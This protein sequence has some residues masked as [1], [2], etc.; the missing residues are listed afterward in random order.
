MGATVVGAFTALFVT[1][2]L[3][4][5]PH[6][7]N[8]CIVPDFEV[9]AAEIV[10]E[11]G[12]ATLRSTLGS[13]RVIRQTVI[14][15]L[16]QNVPNPFNP[17]TSIAYSL[18]SDTHVVLRV[19]DVRGAVVRTLVNQRRRTGLHH[20]DWDGRNDNGQPVASGMY[21]YKLVAGS[22]VDTKKMTILK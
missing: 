10:T 3:A 18:A 11:S 12:T 21:F 2:T 19:Y 4:D 16:S 9:R 20:V 13:N 6:N 15:A 17:T 8:C 5:A 1:S 14:D 22:F 7:C